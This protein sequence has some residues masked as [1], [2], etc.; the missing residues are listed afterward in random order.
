MVNQEANCEVRV[1]ILESDRIA[2]QTRSSDSATD[3]EEH[4]L[5]QIVEAIEDSIGN[6]EPTSG[7]EIDGNMDREGIYDNRE[8]PM[9]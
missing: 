7:G 8:P 4:R 9:A 3:L 1:N 2:I 6:L 5:D